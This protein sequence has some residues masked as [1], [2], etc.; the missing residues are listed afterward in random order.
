MST[1][2]TQQIEARVVEALASFGPDIS[3]VT[4]GATFEE[5]DIDSLDLAELTQV[6]EDAHGVT[7]TADDLKVIKNVGDVLDLIA[8]RA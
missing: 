6:V 4:R 1:A 3:Q 7:L 5:L 2:T 8:Q